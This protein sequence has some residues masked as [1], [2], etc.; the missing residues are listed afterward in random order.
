MRLRPAA[1]TVMGTCSTL[2]RQTML[3]LAFLLALVTAVI[4]IDLY[5]SIFP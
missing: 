5:R 4:L 2:A 1:V 3:G